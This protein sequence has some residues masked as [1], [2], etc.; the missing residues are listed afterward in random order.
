MPHNNTGAMKSRGAAFL[1]SQAHLLTSREHLKIG[2]RPGVYRI[3]AFDAKGRPLPVA[4][5]A[6]VDSLGILH[7]GQS[8]NLGVRLRTFRQAAEG[9]QAAH[10]AGNQFHHW[11]FSR[12]FPFQHLRFDYV[13]ANSQKEAIEWERELHEEYRR[14]FLDRPPLDG[15]SGQSSEQARDS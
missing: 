9:L 3:R 15:T 7:I 11:G 1:W 14:A 6:G 2:R 13:L 5:A 12:R 8:K 4:R 10:H